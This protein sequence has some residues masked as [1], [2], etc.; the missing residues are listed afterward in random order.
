MIVD[1][2]RPPNFYRGGVYP[3]AGVKL[4]PAWRGGWA[5]LAGD[6]QWHSVEELLPAMCESGQIVKITALN[7]LRA[8][9]FLFR[10]LCV[11]SSKGS[12]R[13]TCI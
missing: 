4:G 13:L 10:V 6:L 12:L 2:D 3:G 9:R 8:G 5:I 11:D 7:M 1:P